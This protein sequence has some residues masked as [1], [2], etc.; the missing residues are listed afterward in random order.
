MSRLSSLSAKNAAIRGFSQLSKKSKYLFDTKNNLKLGELYNFLTKNPKEE[1]VIFGFTSQI[2]F[3]L[4]QQLK[5][6]RF[7]FPKIMEF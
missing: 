7:I 3:H 4:I 6:K 2:W 5:K 1:F